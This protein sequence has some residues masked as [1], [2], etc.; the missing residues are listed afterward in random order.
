[1]EVLSWCFPDAK[2][3]SQQANPS[4]RG[5]AAAKAGG[6]SLDRTMCC[7][8][9]ICHEERS[10]FMVQNQGMVLV[11]GT[12]TIENSSESIAHWCFPSRSWTTLVIAAQGEAKGQANMR[13]LLGTQQADI[14]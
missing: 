13:K 9:W 11:N 1:M 6:W 5:S 8:G 12:Q 3:S 2:A 7:L 10:I 14:I 4:L